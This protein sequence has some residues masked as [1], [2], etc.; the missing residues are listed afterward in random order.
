MVSGPRFLL[1]LTYIQYIICSPRLWHE[2]DHVWRD[3]WSWEDV[4]TTGCRPLCC[5]LPAFYVTAVV[6]KRSRS[7]CHKC[8]LQFTAKHT[9]TLRI[10]LCMKW[11]GAWL[12]GVHRTC[13]ETAAISCGTSH[14]SAVSTPPRWI[15]KKTIL[16]ASHSCT[17]TCERSEFARERRTALYKSDH[18]HHHL[19]RAREEDAVRRTSGLCPGTWPGDVKLIIVLFPPFTLPCNASD[20]KRDCQSRTRQQRTCSEMCT[21]NVWM[22]QGRRFTNLHYYY[23][24]ACAVDFI[25]C[26]QM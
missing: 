10:W 23:Y 6:L 21:V 1:R 2:R 12:Y 18:H 7:F 25:F 17:I 15:F 19:W 22:P 8:R 11:H 14:A 9:Y 24:N 26:I 16:K 20:D 4:T 5:L 3:G 13:A